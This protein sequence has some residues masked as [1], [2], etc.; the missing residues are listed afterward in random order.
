MPSRLTPS[1][2]R[3]RLAERIDRLVAAESQD[4]ATRLLRMAEEQENLSLADEPTMAGEILVENSAWLRE[5][6]AFPTRPVPASKIR[7]DR[8]V[9]QALESETLEEFLSLLYHDA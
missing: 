7:H 6:A 4:A 1:E 5:R 9:A 3:L 2:Y 8:A